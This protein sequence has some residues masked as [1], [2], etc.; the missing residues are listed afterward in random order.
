MFSQSKVVYIID[1]NA[2]NPQEIISDLISYELYD[3]FFDSRE[4]INNSNFLNFIMS[5][6]Q[7]TV[8]CFDLNFNKDFKTNKDQTQIAIPFIS[9]HVNFPI[10]LGEI[11]WFYKYD[12]NNNSLMKKFTY[13]IDGYYLGRVHSLKNTEDVSYCFGEREFIEYN[14]DNFSSL[15]NIENILDNENTGILEQVRLSQEYFN[16]YAN[17]VYKPRYQSKV[18]IAEKVLNNNYYFDK[19]NKYKLKV[20]NNI[21]SRP[22]D[23]TLQGSYNTFINLTSENEFSDTNDSFGKIQLISGYNENLRNSSFLTSDILDSVTLDKYIDQESH[24]INLYE[25]L[26]PEIYNGIFFE[27][28]KNQSQFLNKEVLSKDIINNINIIEDNNILSHKSSLTLSESSLDD[29]LLSDKITFSIPYIDGLSFSKREINSNLYNKET[30][31]IS[32]SPKGRNSVYSSTKDLSSISGL[33]DNI[34]LSLHE[35][36]KLEG[37]LCLIAPE[38]SSYISITNSGNIHINSNQIVIGDKQRE[39]SK[40]YLGHSSEMQSLVLGEQLNEFIKEILLVQKESI[41]L[42]KDLFKS[43]KEI[44]QSTKDSL[45]TTNNTIKEFANGLDKI[46]KA[47]FPPL[48]P[49]FNLLFQN[50]N[51]NQKNIENI[52]IEKYNTKINN[53][54][55]NKEEDLYKR[56]DTIEKNLSKLLSKFVKSS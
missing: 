26:S 48:N 29:K 20:S 18:N 6:P 11:V 27:R 54:K 40:L 44:D 28:I 39:N 16:D 9:S 13:S 30:S 37:K 23:V 41:D 22:E 15:D 5:L 38:N 33:S 12:L 3:Y 31:F 53:F 1:K 45:K 47:S 14:Q 25:N 42:I 21:I 19:L 51:T 49:P 7:N 52:P 36:S 8:F 17:I 34:T 35:N 56:L 4:I 24:I 43:S 2:G 10:K 46:T 55:A 50:L 32:I